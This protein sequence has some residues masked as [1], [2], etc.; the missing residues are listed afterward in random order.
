ML[1]REFFHSAL[2]FRYSTETL[3]NPFKKTILVLRPEFA[4]DM[5]ER[6]NQ[7]EM[8][9]IEKSGHWMQ[10]EHAAIFNRYL[11][12]WLERHFLD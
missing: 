5:P 9:L 2:L 8:Y 6:C 11:I 4:A 10:Q 1:T 3:N 12:D 7:L